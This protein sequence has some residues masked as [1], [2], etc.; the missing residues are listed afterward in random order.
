MR[1]R[2]RTLLIVLALGPPMLAIVITVGMAF[3]SNR[4]YAAF[5]DSLY[6]AEK[7]MK[8]IDIA[9]TPVLSLPPSD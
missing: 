1:Y 6:R 7:A 8:G 2:L 3:L 9:E 4:H 5:R